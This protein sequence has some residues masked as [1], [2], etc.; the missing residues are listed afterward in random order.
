VPA[1]GLEA[2]GRRVRLRVGRGARVAG[3]QLDEPDQIDARVG[4]DRRLGGEG[5]RGQKKQRRA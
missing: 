3:Q 1:P 4:D 2:P 5:R